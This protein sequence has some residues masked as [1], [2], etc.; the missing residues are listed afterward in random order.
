MEIDNAVESLRLLRERD[1]VVDSCDTDDF[2]NLE[3][4]WNGLKSVRGADWDTEILAHGISGKLD[5]QVFAQ[6]LMNHVGLEDRSMSPADLAY[7]AEV[8]AYMGPDY[9]AA[10]RKIGRMMRELDEFMA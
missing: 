1:H 3:R 9:V 4:A 7:W 2:G 6:V 8:V 5:A 10:F